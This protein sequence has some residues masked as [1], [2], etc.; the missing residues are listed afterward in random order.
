V[1]SQL[2]PTMR[3][4]AARVAFDLNRLGISTVCNPTTAAPIVLYVSGLVVLDGRQTQTR[5]TRFLFGRCHDTLNR[6]LRVRRLS[7]RA[8]M[9]LLIAWV[10]RCH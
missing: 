9:R 5:V 8:L 4:L 10:G 1:T 7:T 2:Y 6:L 3:S